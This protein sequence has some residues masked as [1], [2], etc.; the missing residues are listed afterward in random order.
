MKL[1]NIKEKDAISV[2]NQ[3]EYDTVCAMLDTIASPT[4]ITGYSERPAGCLFVVGILSGTPIQY[5]D[6]QLTITDGYNIISYAQFIADN[7][8]TIKTTAL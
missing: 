8:E 1:S 3:Q 2:S 5:T 4:I 6:G 7:S